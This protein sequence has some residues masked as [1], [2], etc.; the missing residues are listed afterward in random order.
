M[1]KFP[2]IKAVSYALA[3]TPDLVRYGS[4]PERELR[5][6]PHLMEEIGAYLRNF[7]QACAYP[8]NQAFI[9]LM[10]PESLWDL[11]R[12]WWRVTYKAT[13]R[14]GPYGE[15]M[16]EDEFYGLLRIADEFDLVLLEESF[17][18]RIRKQLAEHPLIQPSD[19]ERLGA[20]RSIDVIT[21]RVR[22]EAALPLFLGSEV[23]G[24]IASGHEE[25]PFL[26]PGILLENLACKATGILAM[27]WLF[28]Q[29]D[30]EEVTPSDID[31]VLNSGEEAVGDRYQRGAGNLAK[32]MAELSGCT[33]C[34][35]ADVKA[36]CCGP[37][38]S[39]VIAAGLVQ[40]G[41][42][43]N[44]LVVGGGALGKLGM[45]FRGH[46]A[47]KMP[48]IEDV[49]AS[50]AILIGPGDD[51]NPAIRLDAIGK[52]DVRYG[53]SAQAIAEA[54]I[55]TPLDKL[56]RKISDIDKYAVELHNPEVTEPSG[57]GNI[58]QFNYRTIASLGVLRGEWSRSALNDFER[59]H[60]LP[61]FSPTQ[62]HV[63]SAVPFLAHARDA[64]LRGDLKTAMFVGK[65]SLFLGKM[66][67]L[68]DGMSF[69][70]EHQG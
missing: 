20:G 65:G 24:C 1:A 9:G 63:P 27:R 26:T 49:L 57:S 43:R 38:H 17:L 34:T 36:F 11:E 55:A 35:G 66:T 5:K 6:D 52:H 19:L 2:V 33:N 50:F 30:L 21:A 10:A 59:Q 67:N 4:K 18:E 7:G 62:G 25:D 44:V 60:G 12:P 14:F 53:G 68:S 13:S 48:I 64:M 15:I 45:K 37:I 46:L 32:A 70:L 31:Y 42:F 28:K 22:D 16:P 69:I 29:N 51:H 39:V 8:P 58:P 61:G 54:L 40:A 41:I 56:G 3:H 23:V 47:A